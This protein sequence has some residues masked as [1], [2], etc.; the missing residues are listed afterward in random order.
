MHVFRSTPALRLLKVSL[1]A[2]MISLPSLAHAQ[3]AEAKDSTGNTLEEIV[4]TA[5][6]RTENIQQTPVAVTA[7]TGAALAERGISNISDIAASTPNLRF[8]AG[9]AISGSSN[10]T[11]VFIRGI[12]QTDFN[13]TIDPGVGLYLDGVYVSRSVGALFETT[14]IERIEVLRGPQG[15]LFGKNTI[16]GAVSITS[17]MPGRDFAVSGEL[18]TGSFNRIDGKVSLN[19]PVSDSVSI[20]AT[21]ASINRDGNVRR[22]SDGQLSGNKKQLFGRLAIRAELSPSWTALL[23]VDATRAREATIGATALRIYEVNPDPANIG[24]HFPTVWNLAINGASCAPPNA[25]RATNPVCYNNQWVTGNPDT[26]WAGGSNRSDSDIWGTSLVLDGK[27]SGINVKSITA[28]RKL[29]SS[30]DLDTDVSPLPITNTANNYS[31]RQFS[32]EFQFSGKALN[33]KL[34]Y[35]LGLYYLKETGTD[36]N[37]L[38]TV[39]AD[40]NSGGK[41]DNDSYAAFAQLGYS[42]TDKLSVTLG[43]RFTSESKRF[44]PDQFILADRTPG[45]QL[46]LL[47]RCLIS[48]TPT[49]PPSPACVADPTLNPAGNRILPPNQVKQTFNEFTPSVT[50]DYKPNDDILAYATL[51]RGFKSGGFTQRIFPPEPV[52]PS[53]APE[54]VN[55]YEAG[56]KTEL[57]DRHLRWNSAL[58]YNDYKNLQII[59]L[60]GFSPKVRNAGAA[61]MWGFETEAEVVVSSRLRFNGSLSYLNAKYTRVDPSARPVTVGSRLVNAPEWQFALGGTA[62]LLRTDSLDLSLRGDWSHSSSLS[63]DA[64][65]TPELQQPAYSLLSAS[66]TLAQIDKR[67]SIAVGATNLTDTRYLLTG[68]YN[69]SIGAVYGVYNRPREWYARVGFKF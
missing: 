7:L 21:A 64:E 48:A 35:L 42:F 6:K 8:D 15:T 20:L 18:T 40:F 58:F 67:W 5:R 27:I 54:Y 47:S 52:T 50:I 25:S 12:G 34:N 22:L 60:D 62:V 19:V 46:L 11:T 66:L 29:T 37:A 43:G 38:R 69:P 16:G 36:I 14:D 68:N 65:N 17:R 9:A 53:F 61:R 10:S 45:A 2:G 4:V 28:Y 63:K 13:L 26:T 33:D 32:Q 59:V 23:S 56:L 1:L 24:V 41:V 31:Q 3:E 30:F 51:S 39:V 55:S 57:F 49:I 44:K